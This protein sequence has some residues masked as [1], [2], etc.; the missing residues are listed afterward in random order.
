MPQS[1]WKVQGTDST[2]FAATYNVQSIGNDHEIYRVTRILKKEI[3]S[4]LPFTLVRVDRIDCTNAA[5]WYFIKGS[6]DFVLEFATEDFSFTFDSTSPSDTAAKGGKLV[7][8]AGRPLTE[9]EKIS[10]PDL[11]QLLKKFQLLG[12]V[13]LDFKIS[14]ETAETVAELR[15]AQIH[16][17][18]ISSKINI[19]STISLTI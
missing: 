5:S 3:K 13:E 4:G 9:A 6:Y 1:V 10:D 2:P 15:S 11:G 18:L 17:L 14:P 7:A 16:T 19:S 8:F 12:V